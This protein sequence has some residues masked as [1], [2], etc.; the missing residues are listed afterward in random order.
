M[1]RDRLDIR[2]RIELTITNA[3]REPLPQLRLDADPASSSARSHQA[4]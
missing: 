1:R 3:K 2:R 4:R